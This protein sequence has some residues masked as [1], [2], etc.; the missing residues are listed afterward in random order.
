MVAK[1]ETMDRQEEK[2]KSPLN[3]LYGR[4]YKVHTKDPVVNVG[5]LI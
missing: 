4:E 1:L 5:E 3:L 2:F